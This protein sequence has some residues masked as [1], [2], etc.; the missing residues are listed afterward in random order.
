M[1][2]IKRRKRM[3]KDK[4]LVEIIDKSGIPHKAKYPYEE[5]HVVI[6]K[7]SKKPGDVRYAPE[8]NRDCILP[9]FEGKWPFRRLKRRLMVWNGSDHCIEFIPEKLDDK[10]EVVEGAKVD[11]HLPTRTTVEQYARAQVVK[12]AGETMQQV[13]ISPLLYVL[14]FVNIVLTC[15]AILLASG[16]IQFV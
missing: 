16:K 13:K 5:N 7:G 8:F 3:F 12:A 11:L 14:V 6:A 9:Y 2:Q 1:E 4:I 10:G 15:G